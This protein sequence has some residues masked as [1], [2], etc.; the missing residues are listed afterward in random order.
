MCGIAGLIHRDGASAV[1]KEMTAMLLSL[2]HRGPELHRVRRLR[3]VHARRICD[4][5]QGRRAGGH[6]HR[7]PHPAEDQGAP[8]RGRQAPGRARRRDRRGGGADRR[9]PF[10]TACAMPATP[11][12]SPPISSRSRAPRSCRFGSGL[13]LIKDLGDASQVSKQ[14]SLGGFHGTHAHRPHP[15]G[16][17]V[18]RR[19]PLG[20]SLLGL[21]LQ[22]HRRGP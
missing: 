4:A 12:S 5:A 19:Y 2:S 15:H 16:D 22:R 8:G 20:P 11:S 9:T 3:R 18:R 10:A 7:P 6:G 13:E 17:R 14:Y 1:G 21:S